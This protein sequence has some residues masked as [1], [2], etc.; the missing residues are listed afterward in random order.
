MQQAMHLFY[1]AKTTYQGISLQQS[2][3]PL[4]L[5]VFTDVHW[6]RRVHHYN[7]LGSA[8]YRLS[9]GDVSLETIKTRHTL[10]FYLINIYHRAEISAK[11]TRL[12]IKRRR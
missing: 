5:F 6:L 2:T 12:A 8:T 7:N 10:I 4:Q 1:N 11:L 3:D 9:Q